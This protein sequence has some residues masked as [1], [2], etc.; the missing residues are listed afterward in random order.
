M[1]EF[2][3]RKSPLKDLTRKD[4]GIKKH[5][6]E[7]DDL[8]LDLNRA[9]VS[10]HILV[11]PNGTQYFHCHVDAS[12]MS[13]GGTLK[14]TNEP[15]GEQVIA[16]YSQKLTDSEVKCTENERELLVLV[17]C[18]KGFRCYLEGAS[19]EVFTDNQIL[20]YFFTKPNLSIKGARWLALFGE[21]GITKMTLRPGRVYV[22]G[23][24]IL[25]APHLISGKLEIR[26]VE[27]LCV[28]INLDLQK[29]YS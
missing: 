12:Q 18:L 25:R 9:L 16:Y 15:K 23:D 13:I 14:Q 8:F 19:F 1:K 17:Y 28:A 11:P 27:A 10:A 29:N 21:F 20:N 4:M 6:T 24:V 3:A 5:G 7:C 2:S 26:H 22:L